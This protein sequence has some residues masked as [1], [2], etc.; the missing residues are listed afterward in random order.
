MPGIGIAGFVSVTPGMLQPVPLAGPLQ[1]IATGLL[2]QHGLRGEDAPN[3]AKALAQGVDAAMQM[4]AGM[5]MVTP[6]IAAAPGAT[7]A[8][9]RLA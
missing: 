7:A 5:A 4:F 1:G 3:L 2:Q 8:P 6:G 9:G